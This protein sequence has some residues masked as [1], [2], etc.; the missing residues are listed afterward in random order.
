ML[1]VYYQVATRETTRP[2]AHNLLLHAWCQNRTG[3]MPPVQY[4]DV[5]KPFFA[6]NPLFFSLS[7]TRTLA[8]CAV[9]DSPVGADCETIRSLSCKAIERV[10]SPSELA[11]YQA[12]ADPQVAFFSFW[13]LKEAWA[14]YTGNG[15]G[16]FPNYTHFELSPPAMSG[17]DTPSF[18]VQQ[19]ND[20]IIA[21][22]SA[23]AKACQFCEISSL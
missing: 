4:T 16:G 21:V 18:L 10:L 23:Q 11:Q 7:H 5:G 2:L 20:C 3:P 8:L 22:C 6:G 13:T 17:L 12:A 9:S 1:T 14:K 19:R 15:L